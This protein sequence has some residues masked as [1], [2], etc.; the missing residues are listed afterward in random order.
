MAAA[1]RPPAAAQKAARASNLRATIYEPQSLASARWRPSAHSLSRRRLSR[2]RASRCTE[3]TVCRAPNS[4][5]TLAKTPLKLG[6]NSQRPFADCAQPYWAHSWRRFRSAF[7]GPADAVG[8]AP[9]SQRAP[10]GCTV[11]GDCCSAH[12]AGQEWRLA[13]VS[14][15]RER[16]PM[17]SCTPF[18]CHLAA[19]GT[20]D[21]PLSSA[22]LHP[23]SLCFGPARDSLLCWLA[24]RKRKEESAW[25][26]TCSLAD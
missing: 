3:Q 23:L 19:L 17:A 21:L 20:G 2:S 8:D 13:T 15:A 18:G 6:P 12:T 1:N 4:C 10:R 7:C 11:A 5:Q 26:E 9:W 24:R 25:R 14:L 22:L 16:R